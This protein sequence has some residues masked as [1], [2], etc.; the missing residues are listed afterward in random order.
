MPPL[1]WWS[2]TDGRGS[3]LPVFASLHLLLLGQCLQLGSTFVG[4]APLLSIAIFF[5]FGFGGSGLEELGGN[6]TVRISSCRLHLNLL[7]YCLAVLSGL[8]LR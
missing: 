6:F 8:L 5:S 4:L 2:L 3:S 1:K 7:T